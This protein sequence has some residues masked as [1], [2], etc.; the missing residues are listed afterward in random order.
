MSEFATELTAL[1]RSLAG[2]Q[3]ADR[4]LEL[5]ELGL[6]GVGTSED[7]GGSG[8]SLGDLVVVIKELAR[9]G[10][11]S[12]I[13]E[14]STALYA[15]G[16]TESFDTVARTDSDLGE[17]TLTTD[18]GI[19]AYGAAAHQIVLIG[20]RDVAVVAAQAPG[21]TMVEGTD[22]A[23]DP[24]ARMRFADVTASPLVDGPGAQ[25]VAGR[26]FLARSAALL[27]TA[28]AAFERTRSYVTEREQ[29]GAPLIEIPAVSAGLAQMAV[30]IR[31][32]QTALERAIAVFEADQSSLERRLAAASSARIVL[33]ETATQVARSA[34]QLHGAVGITREYGLHTYTRRLWAWRDADVPEFSCSARLGAAA[35]SAG[36][37]GLWNEL[38]A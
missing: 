20:D 36:E 29:F 34:H 2:S 21:V 25:A 5:Q 10:I 37:D 1:I 11:A 33:A 22:I 19:V 31:S 12:P 3:R 14:A 32:A 13:V 18:L 35:R 6:V 24:V 16:P 17:P 26:L 28:V 27:G 30:R 7:S 4:W 23:G 15:I 9:A 38:T 8:G